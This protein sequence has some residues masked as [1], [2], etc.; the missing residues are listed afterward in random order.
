[1]PPEKEKLVRLLDNTSMTL[2]ESAKIISEKIDLPINTIKGYLSAKRQGFKSRTEYHNNLIKRKESNT[3]GEYHKDLI[4]KKKFSENY[5]DKHIK[6]L[7][8]QGRYENYINFLLEKTTSNKEE[9]L[10]IIEPQKTFIERKDYKTTKKY[11]HAINQANFEDSRKTI[12]SLVDEKYVLIDQKEKNEFVKYFQEIIKDFPRDEKRVLTK[13]ILGGQT[14]ENMGKEIR[15][16]SKE[17]IRQIEGIAIKR[18]IR[19]I[20]KTPLKDWL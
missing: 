4:E 5:S 18:L 13:R 14:L 17:R 15:G 6:N 11:E 12:D 2:R 8:R 10:D 1:M 20:Q 9:I 3:L 16:L 19:R 7:K